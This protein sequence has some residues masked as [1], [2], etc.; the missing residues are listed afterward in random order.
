MGMVNYKHSF[1]VIFIS[2]F[3][4]CHSYALAQS[5]DKLDRVVSDM[6]AGNIATTIVLTDA[7]LITLGV[8]DFDPKEFVNLGHLDTGDETSLQHRRELKSLSLP[9]RSDWSEFNLNWQTETVLK[10]SYLKSNQSVAI[11]EETPTDQLKEQS[12]LFMAEQRWK[13]ELTERWQ[14]QLGISGQVIWYE[15]FYNYQSI[16]QVYQPILDE[17]LVNTSY[18]ALLLDPSIEFRYDNDIYGNTWQ[19]ISSFRFA[20]GQTLLTDSESQNIYSKVGRFSN[21][22]MFHYELGH[23]DDQYNEL[24]FM[25]KRIDLF[26]DAVEPIGASHYYEVGAGWLIKTPYLSYWLDNIGLGVTVNVGSVLSGGSLVL[27][28]NEDI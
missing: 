8:M 6:T 28:F 14:V 3:L 2:V 27:L 26:G 4:S 11:S 16:L 5:I 25:F 20:M 12:Y 21:R 7:N 13:R 23:L 10:L 18:G 22:L 1:I 19:F 17:H 24:R 9:W 15:N